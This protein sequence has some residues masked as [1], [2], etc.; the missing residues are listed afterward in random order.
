[1]ELFR[2]CVDTPI[3]GTEGLYIRVRSGEVKSHEGAHILSQNSEIST[4][5]YFNIFSTS[6]Y[7]EYT[8]VKEVAITT[9][10]SG[11]LSV[12]LCVLSYEGER[13]IER[14]EVDSE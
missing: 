11:K 9:S 12:G 8:K 13:E 1:M 6:K 3:T 7:A 5:T 10:V 14:V 4:D 2:I